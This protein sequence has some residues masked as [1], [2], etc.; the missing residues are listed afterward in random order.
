ML[1]YYEGRKFESHSFKQPS[2]LHV[3]WNFFNHDLVFA[4]SH[5]RD[6]TSRGL[7]C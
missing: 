1:I 7:V 6:L 3:E 4:T 5:L 2:I